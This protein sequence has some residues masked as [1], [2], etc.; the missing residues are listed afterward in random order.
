MLLFHEVCHSSKIY[1][2]KDGLKFENG[3]L[4]EVGS[5][6]SDVFACLSTITFPWMLPLKRK[7]RSDINGSKSVSSTKEKSR[8]LVHVDTFNTSCGLNRSDSS[9]VFNRSDSSDGFNSSA[10]G[11][12]ASANVGTT[13]STRRFQW[14]FCRKC[15]PQAP[16]CTGRVWQTPNR[17]GEW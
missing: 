6:E 17:Y 2:L 11:G 3:I 5:N 16:R 7:H 8:V 15:T 12:F 4:K 1:L 9:V 10:G 13:G 14:R